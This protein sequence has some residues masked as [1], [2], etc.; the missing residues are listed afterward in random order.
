MAS[1][2]YVKEIPADWQFVSN[3]QD[4][5]ATLESIGSKHMLSDVGCLFVKVG[6]GDY[7]AVYYCERSVLLFDCEVYKLL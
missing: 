7:D 4:I 6:D 1:V 5:E 3:S 2:N